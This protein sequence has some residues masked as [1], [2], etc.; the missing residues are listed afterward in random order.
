MGSH[1]A[2]PLP[3]SLGLSLSISFLVLRRLTSL[4]TAQQ[5][6]DHSPTC[7]H[8]CTGGALLP[9]GTQASTPGR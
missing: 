5:E 3:P 4:L 8:V 7:S 9:E 6:G 1:V 2:G